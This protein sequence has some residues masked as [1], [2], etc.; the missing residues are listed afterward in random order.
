MIDSCPICSGSSVH[1]LRP[2][3]PKSNLPSQF[4]HRSTDDKL[5]C[6]SDLSP[7]NHA[8]APRSEW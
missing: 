6:G 5:S 8:A 2:Y 4:D 3:L 7:R 1:K